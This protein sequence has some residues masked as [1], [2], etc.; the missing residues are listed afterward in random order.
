MDKLPSP[1]VRNCC[2]TNEDICMGCGRSYQEILDWHQAN[3]QRQQLILE[4]AKER[5]EE[6]A[7]LRGQPLR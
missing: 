7:A 3:P 6:M 2:L 1:C 4:S 5:L